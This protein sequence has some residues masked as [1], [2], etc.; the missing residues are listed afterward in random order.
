MSES[1]TLGPVVAPRRGVGLAH[2]AVRD[3]WELLKPRIMLLIVITTVGSLAFAAH[4]WPRT[5]LGRL[6]PCVGMALV[7][8]GSSGVNHWYDRDIDALME[9]TS[10]APGRR[11]G[12]SHRA[13]LALGLGLV[14][15]AAGVGA[16]CWS[17]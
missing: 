10:D 15:A 14:L 7:S 5:S 9:R 12:A 3:Y 8:G 1:S 13:R 17:R 11:A 6:R 16:R 4:G 2:A